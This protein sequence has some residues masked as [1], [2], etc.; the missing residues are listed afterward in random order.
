MK[1][2][3]TVNVEVDFDDKTTP[4]Y[5]ITALTTMTET[6][7]QELLAD[8]FKGS[9]DTINALDKINANNAYATVRWAN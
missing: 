8:T 4:D 5:V 1:L 7:L 9:L 6:Q 2:I 3:H